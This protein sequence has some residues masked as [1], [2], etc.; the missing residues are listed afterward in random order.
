[1]EVREARAFVVQRDS[2][3]AEIGRNR[4][5][6]L[7]AGRELRMRGS[8]IAAAAHLSADQPFVQIAR[9]PA[10]AAARDKVIGQRIAFADTGFTLLDKGLP[11]SQVTL[12]PGA[13]TVLEIVGVAIS[14]AGTYHA[15]TRDD[16]TI[17]GQAVSVASTLSSLTDLISP[18]VPA[19]KPYQP[20]VQG[21]GLI[22]KVIKSGSE[23]MKAEGDYRV[24][25]LKVGA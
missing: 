16:A 4:V 15:F 20:A 14:G 9:G 18:L 2:V 25:Q 6:D 13:D 23:L 12:P 22:L 10:L 21:I 1:M 24:V 5:L 3:A 8:V 17:W 11:L 7:V 19:L